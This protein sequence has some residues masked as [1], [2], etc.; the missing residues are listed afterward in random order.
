MQ[1]A[2][3][4]I[5]INRYGD[6]HLDCWRI[7]PEMQAVAGKPLGRRQTGGSEF[8]MTKRST[9]CLHICSAF[10]FPI[11]VSH[12]I[13]FGLCAYLCIS[14]PCISSFTQFFCC[15]LPL[16]YLSFLFFS[17][18]VFICISIAFF[19]CLFFYLSCMLSL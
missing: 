19:P 12:T 5:R 7:V 2:K 18:F 15:I 10:L 13:L 16:L 17:S 9:C 3:S 1:D 11:A 6:E 14:S 4:N 8:A